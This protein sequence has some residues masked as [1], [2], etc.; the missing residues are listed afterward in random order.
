MRSPKTPHI[1]SDIPAG[2]G[3]YP[4]LCRCNFLKFW[5]I[6]SESTLIHLSFSRR[7]HLQ[8]LGEISRLLP[9]VTLSNSNDKIIHAQA[10]VLRI[11]DADQ[12]KPIPDFR[13]NP[14]LQHGTQF[15]QKIW[16]MISAIRPGETTTYGGLATAAGSPGG[17]RAVGQ[18]CNK[19]PLA[20]LIP[21]HRV[22][23][24]NGLGGFAGDPAIKLKLLEREK[25]SGDAQQRIQLRDI[26]CSPALF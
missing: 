15:Q 13:N 7:I 18:A 14:F 2:G 16:R 5:M 23:A 8:A 25:K 10:M 3:Y 17:A 22:V 4:V 6:T 26:K 20:L 11:L 21:C 24:A 1:A 9:Q 12:E 19:N